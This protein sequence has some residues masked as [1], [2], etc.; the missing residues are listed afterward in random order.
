MPFWRDLGEPARLARHYGWFTAFLC[1]RHSQFASYAL[2]VD[3]INY[4][5]L[6]TV[7]P[8]C[9]KRPLAVNL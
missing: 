2:S 8:P 5:S 1:A 9:W 3:W 7:S 6:E 4:K